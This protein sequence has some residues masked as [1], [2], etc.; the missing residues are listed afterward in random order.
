M[1]KLSGL[2]WESLTC[3]VQSFAWRSDV[4]NDHQSPA[5]RAGT[6]QTLSATNVPEGWAAWPREA[7]IHVTPEEKYIPVQRKSLH[8]FAM[9]NV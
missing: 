4:L 6:I 8:L 1:H 9:W 2:L 3:F 5:G 7:W